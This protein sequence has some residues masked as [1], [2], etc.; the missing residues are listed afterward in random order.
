MLCWVCQMLARVR[1]MLCL[2]RRMLALQRQ[3]LAV[4]SLWKSS[5][6]IRSRGVRVQVRQMLTL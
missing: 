2:V 3:M 4:H 1:E 6:S 5:Q